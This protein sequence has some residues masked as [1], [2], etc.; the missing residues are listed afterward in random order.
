MRQ[1]TFNKAVTPAA[2]SARIDAATAPLGTLA[3][4]IFALQRRSALRQV[5]SRLKKNLQIRFRLIL[6]LLRIQYFARRHAA[7][8][9]RQ[10]GL[11][12]A[13]QLLQ[14][15]RLAA[16]HRIDPAT[17]YAH[18][19]YDAPLGLAETAHYLGR[20]E[21]KNGLYSL[22]CELRRGD[23]NFSLSLSDKVAFTAACLHAGLPVAP[24]LAVARCGRWDATSPSEAFDGDLFVKPVRGRG[25]AAARAYRGIGDGHHLTSDGTV[26]TRIELLDHIAAASQRQSLMVTRKLQ[27][28]PE[29]ADL[30]AQSLIAFRV[31]TCF[32]PAGTPIVTHAMLRTLSK[33]EPDWNTEEEFAAA[34]DLATGR[35][36]PMCGDA[37]MAPDAWWDR[38]PKTGAPVTS[39]VI[40]HWPDLA[41][42]AI[43]AHRAFS[44]RMIVG[45]DLALTPEG[46]VVIE[47]NSDPD[48]HFLQR[49][50]RRMIGRS[51][52]A[53]LL[54]H[55]LQ[56]AASLLS[57]SC[58]ECP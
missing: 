31:F 8:V 19:L 48:T 12:I 36:Q 35:L 39:R 3:R 30:A 50:H 43:R 42:L 34:I 23:P 55:H 13:H 33:L 20:A 45:W 52:L 9:R 16:V 7:S 54:R 11:S 22:L 25:A 40:A 15:L 6:D 32:D 58:A 51:P 53:P 41:A 46:P 24:V 29:I 49:V 4:R 56:A 44:G 57:G 28:H 37:G 18:H 26:L 21:M 14:L 17:Y 38:H 10:R 5:H 27:N 2:S 47:G 1:I